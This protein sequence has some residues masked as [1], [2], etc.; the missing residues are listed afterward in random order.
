MNTDGG[1]LFQ[2]TDST[3]AKL[4]SVAP[5]PGW[6]IYL[7]SSDDYLYKVPIEGGAPRRVAGK[8]IGVSAVSPDGKTLVG[9]RGGWKHNI[10]LVK[11][12]R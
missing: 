1:A 6:M 2:L 7:S 9:A 12:L 11:N 3:G 5:D 4:P 8:A 10:I